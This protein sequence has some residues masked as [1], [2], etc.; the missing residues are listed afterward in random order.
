MRSR[1]QARTGERG[2]GAQARLERLVA[3]IAVAINMRALYGATHDGLVPALRGVIDAL[4]TACDDRKQ[5]SVTFL[6]LDEELVVDDRPLYAGGLHQQ[7]VIK[8]LKRRGI[9]RLTLARG[10]EPGECHDL[11]DALAAGGTPRSTA[12]VVVGQVEVALPGDGNAGEDLGASQVETAM[13]AF[14]GFRTERREAVP[15][16]DELVWGFI[17]ALARS[18]RV[19]LPVVPLRTHD[20]YTFVHSIN[21]SLLVLGQARSFGIEGPTLHAIGLAAL[22]HDV[23]KLSI[24]LEVLNKPGRLD[25]DEW[26]VM[27]GHAELGAR[28]LAG[29]QAVNPLSMLVA[30]EHHLRVDG[31]PSYPALKVPRQ[32]T[33]ASQLTAVADVYD[34]VCTARPYRP[35]LSREAALD[36]LRARAGSFHDPFL[37]GNFCRL[38]GAAEARREPLGGYAAS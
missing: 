26:K 16:L 18:T 9:E 28:Q 4:A 23:G 6:L 3:Q 8:A 13:D 22:L 19:M 35:A 7:P 17:D 10:L 27:M 21:V 38:I 14:L 20:E 32:P 24:P 34:A 30:Y 1:R 37:V 11:V 15:K 29:C 33:L 12:H 2:L 36:V 25:G 5:D 31:Q